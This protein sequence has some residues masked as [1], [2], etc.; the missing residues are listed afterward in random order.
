[1]PL[2]S[3][4]L[5]PG[6]PPEVEERL[7]ARLATAARSVVAA[8]PAGTTVSIQHASTYHRDGRVFAGGA[9][10]RP[11]ASDLVREYLRLMQERD[12]VG[13]GALLAPDFEM[14]FP[15]GV[16]M[17]RF[18]E[19]L[20]WAS[21]RYRSVAKDYERFE[22]CWS[23][24]GAVVFC[25]G[26]LHGAWPDGR[27]FSGIRF[28]DRLEVVDGRIRRQDVWNDLAEATTRDSTVR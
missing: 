24:E 7:A 5:L 3:V 11:V 27:E 19:L 22:E 1:M 18:E 2:I 8:P 14:C 16:V 21:G 25:S 23:G 10:A 4:T 15:G 20:E 12:L 9:P 17:H 6:Y 28:I 13:A 26:T